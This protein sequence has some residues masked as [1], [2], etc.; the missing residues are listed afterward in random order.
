MADLN[1][2]IDGFEGPLDLLLHLIQQYEV[3]IYE[4]PLAEVTDQYL[5]F[6]NTMQSLQLEVAAEYLVVAATL[7]AIKSYQLLPKAPL[8]EVE[9][10][11]PE[12]DL[13]EALLQQL[14]A[15]R[16]FKYAAATLQNKERER[17]QYVGK[18][19]EDLSEF[20]KE[21]PLIKNQVTTIDLFLAFHDVLQKQKRQNFTAATIDKEDVSVSE[22]VTWMRQ[23]FKGQHGRISFA[24]LFATPSRS[25]LVNTFLAVLELM[26]EGELVALQDETFD[27]IYFTSQGSEETLE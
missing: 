6:V 12:E 25:E 8:L 10:V 13:R 24:T 26:K 1:V 11:D 2:K 4:V 3:D 27:E 23:Y 7:L 22:K 16:K 15:Y 17:H 18:A 5:A 19:P 21:L 20:E 9:E 14:L